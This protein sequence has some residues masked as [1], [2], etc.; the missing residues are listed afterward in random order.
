MA[1]ETIAVEVTKGVANLS[2]QRAPVNALTAAFLRDFETCLLDLKERSEV[3]AVVVQS[4]FKVFSAGL[5]LKAAQGLDLGEQSEIVTAFDQVFLTAYGFPK[6]L[7]AAVDGAAIAG[8][9]FFVLV[10][11]HRLG[12]ERS[13]FG[14]AEVRVGADF[15]AGP[16]EVA[17]DTLAPA[18]FRRLLLRG[19]PYEAERA[20][21]AGILDEIVAPGDLAAVARARADEFAGL[22]A[23][24]FAGIKAQM[25]GPALARIR[26]AMER[27]RADGV[28]GWFYPD[29]IAAM[30][31][32]VGKAG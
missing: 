32:M 16:L 26:D 30:V 6:P 20:L 8:G 12:T 10:A 27:R 13:Q 22:P 11:D 5:D 2:L 21:D 28:E 18:D 15:P 17:R 14:L 3:R 29:T 31:K 23:G 7:I 4:P 19:Q 24:A 25:R 9:L 1:S